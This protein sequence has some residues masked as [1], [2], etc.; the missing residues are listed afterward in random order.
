MELSKEQIHEHLTVLEISEEISEVTKRKVNVSFRRLAKILHP[1]KSGDET[2]N[3]AFQKLRYSY[4]RLVEYFKNMDNIEDEQ[5]EQDED[6]F[7]IENFHKFNFPYENKGSFT[8]AIECVLA[9]TWQHY[10]TK[11]LGEP[12]VKINK[13]G[14]E[15]DRWWKT[16]YSGSE[17]T[18]HIYNK[19][20]N[21]KGSKLMLQGGLQS[22]ICSYVFDVLPQI[23]KMVCQNRPIPVGNN[24]S[25]KK[26][27]PKVTC[28]QCK[29][30]SSSMIQMKMH[31][32]NIHESNKRKGSKRL[33]LFTPMD[34]PSKRTKDN[35]CMQSDSSININDGSIFMLTNESETGVYLEENVVM[36][37]LKLVICVIMKLKL[38]QS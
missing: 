35:T 10:L 7:L 6:K 23:Y 12:K 38:T 13:N 19:P 15:C 16:S 9:D 25:L 18:I 32:R 20:K 2:T 24:L 29:F 33:P 26:G 8:V 17:I 4:E 5:E 14:T 11:Q 3:A 21:K 28:D 31:L 1:D 27:K 22:V 37:E 36:T 34:K 30:R